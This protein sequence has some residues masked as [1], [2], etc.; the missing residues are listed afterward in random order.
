M[1]PLLGKQMLLGSVMIDVEGCVLTPTDKER[2]LDP[3]VAGVILFTRNFES[4]GQLQSLTTQI[5]NLRHP[6]LLVAVDHEGGRVQRF[7]EGFTR[8]PAMREL[9]RLYHQNSEAALKLTEKIGW[10]MATELL[11]CGVDFSFAPVLD[12]DYGG[13][14][15][16]GDRAFDVSPQVVG[17]LGFRLMHGMRLAGMASVAKHFPGHGYIHA[18]T[19][20]EVAI[21]ERTFDQITQHDVQPFLKLIENDVIAV[22]PAHVIYPK[23]DS[24]P[25]GFSKVWLKFLREQCHFNGA[26]I[27][28][29]LS[30]QA[31]KN[32][33]EIETRVTLAFE[34]GC[35]LVLVCNDSVAADR[36]LSRVNYTAPPISHARLIRLHGQCQLGFNDLKQNPIW[37][38]S[39]H[40]LHR[41]MD[42]LN[43]KGMFE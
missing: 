29:D 24:F 36:V 35:D 5:H 30:M 1:K 27:S 19:H 34:A 25:A 17:K 28:D 41:F 38:A 20:T 10:I 39:T 9:G 26:I 18:D 33:G 31:A 37:Q 7:K 43:Q 42:N 14:S 22:M 16:I 15:V 11:A 4:V 32:F 12:L 21:D 3:I 2:L 40:D 8:L 13:S 23:V 6:K